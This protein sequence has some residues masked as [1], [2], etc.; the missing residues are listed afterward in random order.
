MANKSRKQLLFITHTDNL[1]GGA[2]LSLIE[3]IKAAM[4]RGFEVSVVV[5]SLGSYSE[6]LEK[7]GVNCTPIKYYYWGRPYSATE[8]QANLTAIRAIADLI[9]QQKVDCVITNTL[10]IPWGALAAAMTDVTHV[11]ISRELLTLHHQHLSEYYDFVKDYSNLVIA[12]SKSNADH[13]RKIASIKDVKQFYSYVDAK[14]LHLNKNTKPKIINVAAR[15]HPDKNQFELIKAAKILKSQNLLTTKVVIIGDFE[16]KDEYYQRLIKFVKDNN[17]QQ[18]IIFTG[19]TKNPIKYIGENDI[20]VRTSKHESLGRTITEAMKLGLICVAADI[21]DSKEAFR[22]GGGNL[23]K[24]GDAAELASLISKIIG[25]IKVYKARAL[26]AQKKA[27]I[28]LA[29]DPSH[30]PFF[31]ALSKIISQPN[32]QRSLRHILPQLD[33]E[34]IIEYHE[35]KARLYKE[36]ADRRHRDIETITNSKAWK[37]ATTLQGISARL[38]NISKPTSKTNNKDK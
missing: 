37:V 29:E 38:K 36:L 31:D 16:V 32:P 28:N 17:M 26:K 14:N 22:L 3:L 34:K 27:L 2:E 21:P 4:Q 12:N 23:Y 6:E 13:I 18:D 35:E 7:I 9:V 15:V 20:F 25:K 8:S 5:P 1:R 10:V 11:W 33:I 19:F 30:K 24:S